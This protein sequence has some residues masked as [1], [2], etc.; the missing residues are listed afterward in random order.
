LAD[1]SGVIHLRARSELDDLKEKLAAETARAEGPASAPALSP[2]TS[3]TIN[4]AD[5]PSRVL[6]VG[7]RSELDEVKEKLAAETARADKAE[8]RAKAAEAML[9][10]EQ[11]AKLG[12]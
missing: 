1:Y 4:L 8:A 10:P 6:Y 2:T 7:S 9:T 12:K 5:Y 3:R 11:K